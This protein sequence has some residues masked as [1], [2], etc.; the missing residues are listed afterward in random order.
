MD[1]K[2]PDAELEILNILWKLGKST[3]KQIRG[4]LDRPRDHA[5]IS[6]LLRRLESR[7]MVRRSK[8]KTS[9]EYFYSAVGNREKT[10]QKLVKNLL[11]RAF[12]GSGI[13][14]VQALLQ[15][16]SISKDEIVQLEKLLD[17]LKQSKRGK[18]K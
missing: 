9:R 8:S 13:E 2:L 15:T 12:D 7:K 16:K 6:T 3:I 10:R 4:V 17:E 1:E 11:Q 5:T 18:T 14:M